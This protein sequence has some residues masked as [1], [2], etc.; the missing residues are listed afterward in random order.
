MPKGKIEGLRYLMLPSPI[1]V[2]KAKK[3]KQG[4]IIRDQKGNP[5][6]EKRCN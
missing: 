5:I 2:Y 1:K 3:D 6:L 4:N